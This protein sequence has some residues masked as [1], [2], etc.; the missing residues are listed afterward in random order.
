M[1][2]ALQISDSWFSDPSTKQSD[3][4]KIWHELVASTLGLTRGNVY[5]GLLEG[6]RIPVRLDANTLVQKHCSILARTGSGKSYTAGVI[7]EFH[8]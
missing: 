1:K 2:Q 5:I 3:Y 4:L 8:S 7:R 6:Q